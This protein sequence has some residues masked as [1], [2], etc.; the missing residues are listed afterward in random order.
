MPQ[1][2][3]GI[4]DWGIFDSMSGKD[5]IFDSINKN[6]GIFDGINQN[7]G[8]FDTISQSESGSYIIGQNDCFVL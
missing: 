6:L 5:A 2:A 1:C 4:P 8:I 3:S 7:R